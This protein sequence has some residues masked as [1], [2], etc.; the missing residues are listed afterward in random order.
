MLHNVTKWHEHVH[1]RFICFY[2]IRG[3][4]QPLILLRGRPNLWLYWQ[5]IINFRS[6]FACDFLLPSNLLR[7]SASH[8]LVVI[9][10]NGFCLRSSWSLSSFL[11]LVIFIIQL[12]IRS[13]ERGICPIAPLAL[14]LTV[15]S[16]TFLQQL[17]VSRC[18]VMSSVTWPLEPQMVLSYWWSVD[19]KSLSRTVA[20]ILS[21]K[22]TVIR[23]HWSV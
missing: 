22:V 23:F 19:T 2:N 6:S 9:T 21:F 20:E 18:H 3:H 16:L 12:E 17:F 13:M 5:V 4:L 10:D 11:A 7:A 8:F 14:R 15:Y 1:V